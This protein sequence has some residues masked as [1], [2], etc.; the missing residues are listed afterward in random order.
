MESLAAVDREKWLQLIYEEQEML[1]HE[2]TSIYF[3]K[4]CWLQMF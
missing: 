2:L 4:K 1:Q 3:F